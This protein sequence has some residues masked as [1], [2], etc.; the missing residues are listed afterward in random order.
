MSSA[1]KLKKY[2]PKYKPKCRIVE[3]AINEG[4]LVDIVAVHLQS[5]SVI[6]SYEE[7]QDIEFGPASGGIVPI[8]IHFTKGG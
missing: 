3:M 6:R 2:M 7:I 1:E 5:M 8:K 4:T